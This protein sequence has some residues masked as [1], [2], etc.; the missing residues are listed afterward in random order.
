MIMP[1][2]N[3][4]EIKEFGIL[5]IRGANA[6]DLLQGQI[7]INAANINNNNSV[8]GAICN[9]KG[10][11]ISSFIV[12]ESLNRKDEIWLILYQD[13]LS[14]TE[15]T[16]KKYSPFYK[17]ELE[18]LS[19]DWSFTALSRNDFNILTKK[20]PDT[21][22][23]E[24]SGHFIIESINNVSILVAKKDHK[25]EIS[26]SD[27]IESWKALNIYALN[28]E[29]GL[30]TSEIYTPHELNYH[31][32]ERIDFNKGCYTGQ[33][34]I[35][36]MHYRAK[37]FPKLYVAISESTKIVS[38]MTVENKNGNK[39]GKVINTAKEKDKTLMLLSLKETN[40]SNNE[41][42]LEDHLIIREINSNITLLK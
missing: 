30:L 4:T 37:N 18:N 8:H 22:T 25:L 41:K 29:I 3:S 17:V 11:V 9:N 26:V 10:R 6:R 32:T 28:A 34:I 27:D 24:T 19:N 31:L 33:E 20:G 39:I 13:V 38:N 21:A 16:L 42:S 23:S 7:T 2:S 5:A 35:A 36:R 12:S 1:I 40:S 14:K 15:E